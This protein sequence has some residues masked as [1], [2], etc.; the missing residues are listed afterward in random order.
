[1]NQSVNWIDLVIYIYEFFVFNKQ[2]VIND[3][4]SVKKIK[5]FPIQ[6][7]GYVGLRHSTAIFRRIC[8]RKS[9]KPLL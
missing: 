3:D 4:M 6:W 9:F 1:M 2:I 8:Y 7:I 5:R